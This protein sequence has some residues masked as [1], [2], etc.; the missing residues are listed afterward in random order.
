MSPSWSEVSSKMKDTTSQD[1]IDPMNR[2]SE[3]KVPP[4]RIASAI[5]VLTTS[6][7]G[8]SSV[9]ASPVAVMWRPMR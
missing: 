4:T 8:I 7:A 1:T 2:A 6:P 5:T 9:R 3:S